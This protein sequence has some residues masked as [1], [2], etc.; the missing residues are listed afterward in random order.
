MVD[1]TVTERESPTVGQRSDPTSSGI[2]RR[3]QLVVLWHIAGAAGAVGMMVLASRSGDDA[4]PAVIKLFVQVTV[5]AVLAV[6]EA[7]TELGQQSWQEP[8]LRLARVAQAVEGS[9]VGKAGHL[10]AEIAGCDFLKMMC[11]VDNQS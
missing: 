5:Q 10:S 2:H 7:A 3:L 1:S 11:F 4:L 8:A 6:I 9:G